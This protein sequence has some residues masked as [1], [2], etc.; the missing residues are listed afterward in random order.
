M[1]RFGEHSERLVNDRVT[2]PVDEQLPIGG[3]L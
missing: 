2:R 3:D 1:D